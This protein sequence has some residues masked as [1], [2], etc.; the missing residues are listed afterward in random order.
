MKSVYCVLV[1]LLIA[2]PGCGQSEK[3][4]M[5]PRMAKTEAVGGAPQ[6]PAPD[7]KPGGGKAAETPV[8][9]KIKYTADI[10]LITDDFATARTELLGLL[11]KF[12][13]DLA[14][15]DLNLS[16]GSP[17]SGTWRLRIPATDFTPFCD[18]VQKIGDVERFSTDSE[19]VTEEFYDTKRHAESR[20]K[21]R[22]TLVK[23]L[24]KADKD[25]TATYVRMIADVD[26][27]IDRLEGRVSLLTNLTDL[28]TVT[29]T[30]RERQKFIPD[31]P[32]EAVERPG[33][34]TEA[35]K[36]FSDSFG[37]LKAFGISCA[38]LLIAASPWLILLLVLVLPLWF[39]KRLVHRK[40]G[41]NP[42]T[43]RGDGGHG[44]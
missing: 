42:A 20:K 18:E 38:L 4:A 32:P 22:D 19:D 26:T 14:K 30:I 43:Q 36:T 21:Y 5:A 28:T 1:G 3:S 27:E 29:V 40:R 44:G 34:T 41:N 2:T 12:K 16:P 24:E 11:A 23:L 35:G 8:E 33:F 9:R 25:T 39:I 6:K 37:A 13:G 10:R 15:S 7:A 17:K 31:K